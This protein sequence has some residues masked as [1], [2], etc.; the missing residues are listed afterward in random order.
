MVSY[1]QPPGN[2]INYK[3][4]YLKRNNDYVQYQLQD[5]KNHGKSF[6]AALVGITD[7][8]AAMKL[9]GCDI[10]IKRSQL[11]VAGAGE[12]Y[13]TDLINMEVINQSGEILGKLVEILET[14]SGANDV[15]VIKGNKRILI[16]LVLDTWVTEI[17]TQRKIIKVY[18]ENE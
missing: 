9:T 2:L 5:I 4:W 18:W 16:P 15:M 7:R 13:Y 17:D 6:I 8:D 3:P 14:A 12:Y 10:A 1:T 11:P